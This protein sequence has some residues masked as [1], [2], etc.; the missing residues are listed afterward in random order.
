[1]NAALV[2][3][4]IMGGQV[5]DTEVL[6]AASMDECRI[7]RQNILSGTNPVTTR[8]DNKVMINAECRKVER[9]AGLR[10]ENSLF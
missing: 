2:I 3:A 6:E 4:Y 10:S 9:S 1:M 7:T 8:Y 5:I